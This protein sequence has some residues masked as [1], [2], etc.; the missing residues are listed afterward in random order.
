[1]AWGFY[2]RIHTR[3]EMRA[4]L[5]RCRWLS[6]RVTGRQ[7]IGKTTLVQRALN[8]LERKRRAQDKDNPFSSTR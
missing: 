2:G 3:Q 8:E 4:I 5:A 6:A 1:M 7:R